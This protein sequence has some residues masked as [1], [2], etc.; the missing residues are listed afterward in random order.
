M[1]PILAR[2]ERLRI[3]L[4]AWVPL[5]AMLAY[6]LAASSPLTRVE[7]AALAVP[8]AA[9]YAFQTLAS[10]YVCRAVPPAE[11]PL[12]RLLA[13]HGVAAVVSSLLWVILAVTL[14]SFLAA[15]ETFDTLP[16]RF[17]PA[18]VT[19]FLFGVIV[20]ALVS[21]LHSV[22]LLFERAR[23]A[24][25]REMRAALL[26]RDAELKALRA[27]IDPHFLFNSLNSV[28]ALTTSDPA[29]AREMCVL[30]SDFLRRSLGVSDRPEHPLSEE[31]ALARAYLA[32]ERVRFGSR[33]CPEERVEDGLEGVLV[34][35][36]LLQPLVEN[37]VTHGIATLVRGGE[38]VLQ[39]RR[40]GDRLVVTVSNPFDADAGAVPGAGLGLSNVE[41]RLAA[42]YGGRARLDRRSED[43]RFVAEVTLPL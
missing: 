35:P 3:Y 13:T 42:R 10:W 32:I 29:R 37:A 16:E 14:L 30:F 24:E 23:E 21:A 1:H 7:A 43:G 39:A 34:P 41:A 11:A 6:L 38:V 27:Q 36:L 40:S 25:R 15:G 18:L 33:L 28:A 9:V 19:L 22:L 20:Y 26:A 5:A 2:R 31:L 4:A 17:A 8:L 12:P